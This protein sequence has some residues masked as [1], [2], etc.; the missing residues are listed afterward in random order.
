MMKKFGILI[1]LTCLGA[2]VH[3]AS[4]TGW[5]IKSINLPNKLDIG[6]DVVVAVL[7]TGIDPNHKHIKGNLVRFLDYSKTGKD[8]NHGHGTHVAGIIKSVFPPVKLVALKYYNPKFNGRESLEATILGLKAAVEM[9]VDI[10]NYSGGGEEPSAEEL[11]VLR[12]AEAKGIIVVVAAGNHASD[13]DNK[14][15]AF[16]PASYGLSNIISVNAH[17]ERF[18]LLKSSNWG[19]RLVDLAAPGKGITSSLPFNR[20]GRLTGT[21]QATAFV[22]G[23][24]ALLKSRFP[25]L[26]HRRI[27]QIV[28]Q[29]AKREKTLKEYTITGGRIDVGSA[30]LA[31][32]KYKGPKRRQRRNLALWEKR[33]FELLLPFSWQGLGRIPSSKRGITHEGTFF[34]YKP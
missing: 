32:F 23:L 2:I 5:G 8:D 24:V 29:S 15:T 19:K 13:I 9:N 16:Y 18:K 6:P 34:F 20:A 33:V 3:G 17:D 22:C 10:I 11:K 28:R 12:M 31:A 4:Y 25:H 30:L 21:S 14:K 27:K 7:D 26:D 1:F